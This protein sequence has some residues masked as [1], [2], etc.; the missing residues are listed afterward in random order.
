MMR[1]P[2]RASPKALRYPDAYQIIGHFLR[3]GR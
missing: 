2:C 3:Y 1:A